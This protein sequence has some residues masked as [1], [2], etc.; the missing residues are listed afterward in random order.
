VAVAQVKGR[1]V[2]DPHEAFGD[3]LEELFRSVLRASG[4]GVPGGETELTLSQ[5][6]VMEAL[7]ED[8][9]TVSEVA[10]S[11]QVAVPTATRALRALE[12]RGFVDRRR[13]D[14]EDRRLVTVALTQSGHA[15]LDEKRAWVRERQREIFEGLSPAERRTV[16]GTL[17][18]L[19]HSIDE[20]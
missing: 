9:L 16:T 12:R 19:A 3:A 18:A 17:K 15:V 20:L 11:A 10:R 4:R 6:F 14:D 5:Y 13:D 2:R 7:A 8:E 1:A